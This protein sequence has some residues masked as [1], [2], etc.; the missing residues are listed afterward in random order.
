MTELE[1][2]RERDKT[3]KDHITPI[4]QGGS[5]ACKNLQPVCKSCN[6]R[7]GP[8]NTDHRPSVCPDWE[9]RL[10][11]ACPERL[12]NACKTP[13]TPTT[14]QNKTEVVPKS[15][16]NV[17]ATSVD[18]GDGV[19]G[20]TPRDGEPHPAPEGRHASPNAPVKGGSA[21]TKLDA[22]LAA[23]GASPNPWASGLPGIGKG[24]VF[25]KLASPPGPKPDKATESRPQ[26]VLDI[27]AFLKKGR[28]GVLR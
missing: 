25:G 27:P 23:V 7:K 6:S 17:G 26:D 13:A 9:K 8:D 4:Y 22:S 28:K 24:S 18:L 10:Q 14:L 3:A 15:T 16:A 12:Q 19:L 5:D 2:S 1:D 21:D 11:N 20:E